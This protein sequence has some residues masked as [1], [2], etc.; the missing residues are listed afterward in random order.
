[1]SDIESRRAQRDSQAGAVTPMT[2]RRAQTWAGLVHYLSG[3]AVRQ[4]E[5]ADKERA[6]RTEAPKGGDKE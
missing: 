5:Q 6:S 3:E 2:S 1:M 4:H